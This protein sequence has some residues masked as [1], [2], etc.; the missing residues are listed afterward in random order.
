MAEPTK[1]KKRGT[2]QPRMPESVFVVLWVLLYLV[3]QAVVPI[4]SIEMGRWTGAS[5]FDIGLIFQVVNIALLFAL[6]LAQG[7]LLKKQYGW[8]F[9]R[10]ALATSAGAIAGFFLIFVGNIIINSLP[11][12]ILD[13]NLA[14]EMTGQLSRLTVIPVIM[15]QV[16]AMWHYVKQAWLWIAGTVVA[17]LTGFGLSW[18]ISEMLF[19]ASISADL[20]SSYFLTYTGIYHTVYGLITGLTLVALVRRTRAAHQQMNMIDRSQSNTDEPD[21]AHRLA[22]ESGHSARSQSAASDS[23]KQ[24]TASSGW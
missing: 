22:D 18:L 2:L 5:A 3:L 16:W 10:W 21:A 7:W 15:A 19:P 23:Q 12:V 14:F 20:P 6:P 9:R 24:Q 4:L 13:S 8:S 17:M 11:G 1:K